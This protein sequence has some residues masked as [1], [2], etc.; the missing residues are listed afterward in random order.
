MLHTWFD[1]KASPDFTRT[2]V[3][4]VACAQC[5]SG[6]LVARV[7]PLT[8]I[9]LAALMAPAEAL[10]EPCTRCGDGILRGHAEAILFIPAETELGALLIAPDGSGMRH[11]SADAAVREHVLQMGT[12]IAADDEQLAHSFG[13]VVSIRGAW[14]RALDDAM[15][16]PGTPMRTQVAPGQTIFAVHADTP[17]AMSLLE[18]M[19][20]GY[21]R[22]GIIKQPLLQEP[23]YGPVSWIGPYGDQLGRKLAAYL[24]VETDEVERRISWELHHETKATGIW[25]PFGVRHTLTADAV[26]DH[27]A[28]HG[29]TVGE[30]ARS[31]AAALRFECEKVA[32]LDEQLILAG[33]RASV[34]HANQMLLHGDN[35]DLTIDAA[36]ILRE[37][38]WNAPALCRR[39][40]EHLAQ[41]EPVDSCL[42][43]CADAWHV[44]H[45]HHPDHLPA[46]LVASDARIEWLEDALG[47]RYALVKSIECS[48]AVRVAPPLD[49][50]ELARE[51]R[52]DAVLERVQLPSGLVGVIIS[53]RH[54]ASMLG[55]PGLRANL[56]E[57]LDEQGVDATPI[58]CLAPTTD[59]IC[60]T[61]LD[62]DGEDPVDRLQILTRI[63]ARPGELRGT[64]LGF[65][66]RLVATETAPR[67]SLTLIDVES[68]AS[69]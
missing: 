61:P 36:A 48:H 58:L 6:G 34:E 35:G 10:A 41:P 53:G 19:L 66:A 38:D 63:A 20:A 44:T 24:I 21:D 56:R 11:I 47:M 68:N 18:V 30:S 32:E 28:T 22:P 40:V 31:L 49:S 50:L 7:E 29:V 54:V 8:E 62:S 64:P 51:P 2:V 43:H 69:L 57:R 37:W 23:P 26:I 39:L 4:T 12:P 65:V 16:L 3:A 9:S 42:P 5:G 55:E 17:A 13:R 25:R 27:A 59:V 1:P 60:A 52:F 15:R 45:L 14:R 67:G 46:D 33:V